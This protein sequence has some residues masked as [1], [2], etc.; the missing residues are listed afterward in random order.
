MKNKTKNA[1]SLVKIIGDS[2]LII[3]LILMILL[4][5]FLIIKKWNP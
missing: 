2:W 1:S 5:L 3:L 4:L